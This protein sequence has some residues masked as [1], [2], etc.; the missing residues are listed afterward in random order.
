MR[1]QVLFRSG[2][3]LLLA[4]LLGACAAGDVHEDGERIYWP[5]APE[6]PRFVFETTLR[7]ENSLKP[8]STADQMR[9]SISGHLPKKKLFMKPFGVAAHNGVIAVTDTVM[10]RGFVF[11][12]WRKSLYNFG[13]VGTEGILIKPMGVA[14]DAQQN[15]YV[16]DVGL[17][18]V[19]VYDSM[20]MYLRSLGESDDFD[21]PVGVAV[22]RDGARV[23]V[24][25]A[26]GIDSQRHRLL[27]FDGAGRLLKTVGRR[28]A[29]VG[30]FNLPTQV[31]VSP[32]GTV[33]VLDGGNFRIQAFSAEGEYLRSWGEVGRSYGDLARPRGLAVDDVGNVYVTDA[34]YR[35]FQVFN[36]DGELLLSVGGTGLDDRP[37]Q[38]ALPAG[39]AVDERG[40]VFVVDQL[41]MK[42]DV[43][44]RLSDDES[45]AIMAGRR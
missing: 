33:Y 4:V 42:I 3:M 34:A 35:N 9:L 28:G 21:R 26:G 16:A 37:G 1:L 24:V 31:A 13:S 7:N 22:T 11:N 41:F 6:R 23:Y 43:F 32:D 5:E 30:N 25:D 19:L 29:E 17:R 8:I 27:I 45:L 40:Y 12:L 20:G 18:R 44:R 15:I 2:V 36:P 38:F 39:I 14:M 10:R